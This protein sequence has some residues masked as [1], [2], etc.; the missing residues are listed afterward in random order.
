MARAAVERESIPVGVFPASASEAVDFA[1]GPPLPEVRTAPSG[2]F[3][4]DDDD[5]TY[6]TLRAVIDC[7]DDPA[8]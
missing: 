5:G 8:L 7:S 6:N 1:E 4:G 2:A 3:A